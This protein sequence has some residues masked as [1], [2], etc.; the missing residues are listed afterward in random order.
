MWARSF[1][2]VCR[3]QVFPQN[4]LIRTCTM[5]ET[6]PAQQPKL[7]VKNIAFD[8][9]EDELRSHFDNL[10]PGVTAAS[11][12]RERGN[13]RSRGFG[14]VTYSTLS[15]AQSA[16]ASINDTTLLD[17]PLQVTFNVQNES[18]AATDAAKTPASKGKVKAPVALHRVEAELVDIGVNLTNKSLLPRMREVL[19]LSKEANVTRIMVTGT[20]LAASREAVDMVQKWGANE[21]GVR[22]F[23]TAGVHPHDATRTLQT[24]KGSYIGDIERLIMENKE[25]VVAVGECGLDFDRNFST[26]EDQM[27]VFE[28]Q[29]QLAQKLE[30]PVFLHCRDAHEAFISVLKKYPAVTG[31]VHCYT[32]PSPSHLKEYI[33]LG[34]CIGITGWVCDERRGTE[35]ASIVSMIPMDKLLVETDAPYLMPRNI[36]GRK[37]KVNEPGM[38]GWVVKKIAECYGVDE[39]EIGRASTDNAKRLFKI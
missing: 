36:E 20:S 18:K 19:Q 25:Q 28:E 38:L 34:Y 1:L 16:V 21:F 8:V 29:M 31:V 23:A 32:D 3:S 37:P 22:L 15:L 30:L 33:D 6:K 35:L 9:S 11:I 14:Y 13:N 39:V 24:R 12:V 27:I 4:R 2:T 17:R 7:F 10:V 26:H 5:P